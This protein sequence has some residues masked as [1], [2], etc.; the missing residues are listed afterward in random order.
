MLNLKTN[1]TTI[2][3]TTSNSTVEF[4]ADC[5]EEQ[6]KKD[7]KMNP[8]INKVYF[9]LANGPENSSRRTLWIYLLM[10]LSIK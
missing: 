6:L 7:L 2:F 1:D 9:F 8:N 4:K 3:C 5:I 10:L